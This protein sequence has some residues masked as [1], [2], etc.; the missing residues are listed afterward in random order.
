MPG[1][2]AGAGGV[3]GAAESC[4]VG[5]ERDDVLGEEREVARPG[6]R[7]VLVGDDLQLGPLRGEAQDGEQEIFAGGSV[8]P[9]GAERDMRDAAGQEGLLAGQ[10]RGSV[11]A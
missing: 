7:A 11:D 10:F 6:G 9:G 2:F 8:D 1:G 5:F 3:V 4:Q